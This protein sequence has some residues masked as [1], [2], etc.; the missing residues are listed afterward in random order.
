[1]LTAEQQL[2]PKSLARDEAV[3]WG[4]QNRQRYGQGFPGQGDSC[5]LCKAFTRETTTH[6]T[7]LLLLAL[8]LSSPLPGPMSS[9]ARSRSSLWQTRL[10]CP[11]LC[12]SQVLSLPTTWRPGQQ[13]NGKNQ[14]M[15]ARRGG[16]REM[17]P[18]K[19]FCISYSLG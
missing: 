10:C 13:Q 18:K 7:T 4:W 15:A 5:Q 3:G 1:M 2:L 16:W 19:H 14:L 12:M 17:G 6:I 11:Q 8:L 9:L